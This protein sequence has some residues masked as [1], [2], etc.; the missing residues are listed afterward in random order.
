MKTLLGLL[1]IFGLTTLAASA[2]AA[3]AALQMSITSTGVHAQAQDR[4]PANTAVSLDVSADRGLDVRSVDAVL[5]A[6]SGTTLRI[7][8]AALGNDRFHGTLTLNEPGAYAVAL[9]TQL[10]GSSINSGAVALT[11]VA[12]AAV[13][14]HV[15]WAALGA[16]PLI[17][18][19]AT[20]LLL[21]RR[22]AA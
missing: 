4:Y 6:P 21:R 20:G 2:A 14:Q 5:T 13:P 8:L 17:G 1:V 3:P 18:F 12:A 9:S 16:I 22:R 11:V 15:E 19:A 10:G 7:P